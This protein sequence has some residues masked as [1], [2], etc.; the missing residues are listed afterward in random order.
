MLMGH[1]LYKQ[2]LANPFQISISKQVEAVACLEG[3][4]LLLNG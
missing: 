3:L 1:F 4:S 2:A